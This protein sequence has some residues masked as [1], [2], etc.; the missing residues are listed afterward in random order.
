MSAGCQIF[1]TAERPIPVVVLDPV[2]WGQNLMGITNFAY[3]EA[4]ASMR[5]FAETY[6]GSICWNGE[7]AVA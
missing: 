5:H 6:Q 4:V 1:S 3:R 7:S 2:A